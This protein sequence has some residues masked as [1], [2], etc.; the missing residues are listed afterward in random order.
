MCV[1]K[2]NF[3]ILAIDT[4]CDETSVAVTVDDRVIANVVS[5]QIALHKKYGGVV[6]ILAQRA[7]RERIDAVIEETINR[8]NKFSI[9]N[10]DAI[11]VT[12]G[13]GLAPA[14]EV[15]IAKAKELALK[16]QKSLIA[17]NH[18]EAHLLSSFAKN[19][20]GKNLVVSSQLSACPTARRVVGFPLLGLLI[21]GGHTQL[22]LM[23]NFGRYQLIGETLDDAL[24]EAYDKIAKILE[25]GYPGGPMIERLAKTGNPKNYPLPVPM[26]NRKDLNFSFSGLKTA[27]L[28]LVKDLKKEQG[29][30]LKQIICDICASFQSAAAQSLV[31]KLLLAVKQHQPKAILMGGGVISNLYIRKQIRKAVKN[32][33][34]GLPYSKKLFTDNAGMIGVCA[35]FQA[36]RSDFVKEIEKIDRVP[37]LSF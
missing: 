35:Y 19:S 8:A 5:S 15:G 37:G 34:I 6:P 10:V 23:K 14:L 32:L 17:V 27:V 29:K 16:F 11:A 30:L 31:D 36:K 7:H 12:V 26:R 22:V 33:P 24:G 9:N 3:T 25:L 20:K 18:M 2:K 4:S 28:Y 21:S 13:P 1:L